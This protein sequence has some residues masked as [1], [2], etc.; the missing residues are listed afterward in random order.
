MPKERSK[1][2]PGLGVDFLAAL[3][4][5]WASRRSG[6]AVLIG[7]LNGDMFYAGRLREALEVRFG[8]TGELADQAATL[9]LRAIRDDL[10]PSPRDPADCWVLNWDAP[11]RNRYRF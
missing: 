4:T 10:A 1:Q 6:G 2:D 7:G 8:L 9:V 5:V 11:P 3:D